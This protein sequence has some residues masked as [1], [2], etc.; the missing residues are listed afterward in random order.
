MRWDDG[1]HLSVKELSLSEAPRKE[2]KNFN[3]LETCFNTFST[4]FPLL[5]SLYVEKFSYQEFNGTLQY[6]RDKRSF[7][8]VYSS[9]QEANTHFFLKDSYIYISIDTYKNRSKDIKLNGK[10]IV[11]M[12]KL[13]LYS[14]MHLNIQNY[15]SFDIFTTANQ[16]KLHYRLSSQKAITH[17]NELLT[18]LPMPK[19]IDFWANRAID[20]KSALIKELYGFIA[21]N[22]LEDAYK[23]LYANIVLEKLNYTYNPKLDAIHT[24]TTQLEFK[25]GTLFIYPKDAY[26]YG[27][28][29]GKSW[30]KID[31]TPKKEFLTLFLNFDGQLN[32]DVLHILQTYH[33]KVPFLQKSGKTKTDLKIAVDLRTIAVDAQ[34]K[35][36]TKKALFKYLG[37]DINVTNAHIQLN[38]YDV[39]IPKMQ[40]AYKDLASAN[41][42]ANYNAKKSQGKIDFKLQ[43]LQL[44]EGIELNKKNLPIRYNIAK[45]GDSIEIEASSWNVKDFILNLERTKLNFNLNTLKLD[46][47][48]TAFSVANNTA[49]GYI[50]GTF[51]LHNKKLQ[52]EL[53]LLNFNYQGIQ[54]LQTD[55]AFQITYD[56][57]L[58]LYAKDSIYFTINGSKY[59]LEKLQANFDKDE[60]FLKHTMLYIGN[61]IQTKIYA[62]HKYNTNKAYITLNKFIL[63]NPKNR[64]LLYQ[65][66]KIP[67]ILSFSDKAI[68]LESKE[69]RAHFLSTKKFWKLDIASLNILAKKSPF[70]KKYYINNGSVAFQKQSDNTHVTFNGNIHYKYAL[71]VDK[72]KDIKEYEVE[73]YISKAQTIYLTVNKKL[74]IKIAKPIKI[75]LHNMG[76]NL[77]ALVDFL[78]SLETSKNSKESIPLFAKAK[79]GFIKLD[80]ERKALFD[81]LK[82]QYF[83]EI[84]T[85]QLNH[86]DAKAGFKLQK[87]LFHLYGHKFND[88]FMQ[89]LFIISKFKGGSL[90]FSI[91]GKLQEYKGIFLVKNT[92]MLDY[93]IL[94]NVLALINTV[95]SLATFSL[96]GYDK[97]GIF[98]KNAYMRF[99]T[100]EKNFHISDLYIGSKEL[101]ILGKGEINLHNDTINLLMNLQTDLGSDL[102][103]VP[104]VGYILLDGESVSTSLKVYGPLKDPKVETMLAQD[105][106]V[107]PLN[108]ILRT[109]TLPYKLIINDSFEDNST[110]G[111]SNK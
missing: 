38:N 110:Q 26:S 86:K 90:D 7:I 71:L 23:N 89:N 66:S 77:G 103:K 64:E 65:N 44:Q 60:I 94:N 12:K 102:S 25:E 20:A 39:T 54:S 84:L 80:K 100:K 9:T 107:A 78:N 109:L 30:L 22:A 21:L 46:I 1:V 93:V 28:Y 73:G 63:K 49:N 33:I 91:H 43:K 69:L 2:T 59:K 104:L 101:K 41:L 96:P 37:L 40:V 29:L 95:P 36:Y 87:N 45:T 17:I 11:D 15:A 52:A 19:E 48:P 83:N 79:N 68:E 76:I 72:T 47:P 53:D 92:T 105:I 108:I 42:Q 34:G 98:V 6:V 56:K 51:D 14:K 62:K 13:E 81:T 111:K 106:A 82:I 97:N 31:L 88:T 67:L 27:M 99:E 85:A 4:F 58:H 3:T 70:L 16:E 5:H 24:K 18:L 8:R 55:T 35:F 75:S 50:L 10:L 32:K 57:E 61:Y 74:N